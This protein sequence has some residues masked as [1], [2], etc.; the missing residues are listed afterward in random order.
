MLSNSMA[1]RIKL[2]RK[3]VAKNPQLLWNGFNEF[4]A[5]ATIEI[6]TPMQRI[7]YLAYSYSSMML[8]ADHRE[9][10]LS[11]DYSYYD[12]IVAALRTIGATEQADILVAAYQALQNTTVP[13][14]FENRH[15][16]AVEL[17]DLTEF[18][19]AFEHCARPI[20]NAL[21]DFVLQH[22]SEFVEWAP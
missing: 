12:E 7:A 22:E 3:K 2:S 15:V 5:F 16:A 21:M 9:Y 8:M 4:C 20:P 17:A 10:F 19:D 18:D 13:G 1:Y 11:P 14:L 6:F